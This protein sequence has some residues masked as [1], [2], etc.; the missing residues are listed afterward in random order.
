MTDRPK[1]SR[2]SPRKNVL[3]SA[4]VKH[5]ALDPRPVR[6]ANLSAHGALIFGQLALRE[7]DQIELFCGP[8]RIAAQVARAGELYAGLSFH[9]SI[10]L[11]NILPKRIATATMVIKDERE[12]DF[13]RPG[14]RGNQLSPDER[15]LLEEWKRGQEA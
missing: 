3:L 9:Q 4:T 13:R 15:Q 2:R 7:Q 12:V 8:A 10:E 11:E 5:G 6:I 1:T 14:F